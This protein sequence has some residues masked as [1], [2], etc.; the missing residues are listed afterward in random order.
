MLSRAALQDAWYNPLDDTP[1][2]FLAIDDYWT[3]INKSL[4]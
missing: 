3:I 1:Q 2:L 4:L